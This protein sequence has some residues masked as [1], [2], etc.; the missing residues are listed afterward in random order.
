M[1][2][3]VFQ[4]FD[5]VKVFGFVPQDKAKNRLGDVVQIVK[6]LN[7]ENAELTERV[8]ELTEKVESLQTSHKSLK[9]QL[10]KLETAQK[11]DI[12]SMRTLVEVLRKE[13]EVRNYFIS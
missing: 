3:K 8:N 9:D 10:I 5:V 4:V 11:A 1:I 7:V 13:L 2:C 12:A 6:N